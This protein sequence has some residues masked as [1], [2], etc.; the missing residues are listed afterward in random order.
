MQLIPVPQ[1]TAT[2]LRSS[3][4]ERS[5]ANRSLS[6]STGLPLKPLAH[7]LLVNA[8]ANAVTS[9]GRSSPDR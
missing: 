5:S 1:T 9:T 6:T 7:G 2:A 4:P 8:A 3:V